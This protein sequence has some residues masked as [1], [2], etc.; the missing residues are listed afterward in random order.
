[1]QIFDCDKRGSRLSS[2]LHFSTA[3]NLLA[4]CAFVCVCV[5]GPDG[6]RVP[7]TVVTSLSG[8]TTR[9]ASHKLFNIGV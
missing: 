2:I 7:C 8:P 3:A 4:L 9:K 5:H 6:Q 1:M